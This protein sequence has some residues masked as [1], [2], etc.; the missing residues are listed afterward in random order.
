MRHQARFWLRSLN[1]QHLPITLP[2]NAN[3]W[4]VVL[5]GQPV[6]VRRKQRAYIIPLPAGEAGASDARDLT[7]L[8]ETDSPLPTAGDFWSRL[9]PRTIRQNAPQVALTTLSTTWNVHPPGGTDVVSSGGDF[10]P[11]KRLTRPTLAGWL[12]ETIAY[13]ST[14]GLAWKFGGLVV[15]A[16]V[17]GL[18]ALLGTGKGCAL[19]LVQLLVVTAVIGILIALLLPATQSA[20]EAARR[21]QCT[22]NLKQIGL[23]LHNYHER[24]GQFPPAAIGPAGVPRDRQFSWIVALLPFLE[25]QGL[26]ESLRLDLPWDDPQNAALLQVSLST[27]L[28]PSDPAPAATDEG[29]PKTSYVAITGAESTQGPGGTRG[30]LG[31]DKSLRLNEIVDGASGT[32]MVAEA[33]DGGPWFAGGFGTARRI[34]SWIETEAWSNHPGGGNVLLADG[35]VRFLASTIDLQTLRHLATAQ[36]AD[37]IADPDFAPSGARAAPADAPTGDALAPMP[38]T[39]EEQAESAAPPAARE[40]WA[41]AVPP[42]A[43]PVVKRGQ[44]ARLSLRVAIETQGKR[45]IR[46]R[47][48][49]GAGELVLE[50]QDQ[51]FARTL[52]WL[53]AAAALLAAWAWRRA[54]GTRRA[55]AVV[56]GLAAPVGLAGLVPLAWSPLADGVL[57]G[58]LAAACLWLVLS[59]AGA[60][61]SRLLART[62]AAV[63]LAI[64]ALAAADATAAEPAAAKEPPA[65][66]QQSRQP[67]LT[68]LIPYDPDG[69]DPMR[70]TRVYMPHDEFLR[71]WKQAHPGAPEQ[72]PAGVRPIVSHAEYAGRLENGLARFDGRLLIHHLGDG[73]VRV[74]L[75]LGDVALEK[76]E[77]DGQPATLAGR[78]T[79]DARQGPQDAANPAARPADEAPPADRGQPAIYLEK[80]G[81][82]VV[83]VR[84]SV[85]VHRLGATGQMTVPLRAAPSGRLLFQLPADDLDV[86]VSGAAGGWRRQPAP[87][88]GLGVAAGLTGEVVNIPLGANGELSIRWQPRHVEARTGQLASADQSVLVEVLDSGVHLQ[89]AVHYRIQQGSVSEVQLRIPPGM[90]IRS[91]HGADVADWS[92][93]DEPATAPD[94]AG[95]RLVVSLKTEVTTG[96]DV[97]ID[98]YYRDLRPAGAIG[99][100]ALEPVGVVRETGRLAIG[101]ASHF[102]VRVDEADRLNQV[103]H[104]ELDLPRKARD[105]CAVFSAYRYTARPWR[106]QLRVDRL[107]PRVEVADRTAVAVAERQASLR[108]LLTADVAGAP[109]AS[110]RLRLPAAM[111]VSQVRVPPGAEWFIQRGDKS[112]QLKVDWSEP[113]IGKLELAVAGS[114]ARDS[115]QAE[116]VVPGVVVEGVAAQRGQLAVY[117]DGD[118]EAVLASSGGARSIDPAALDGVLRV[119]DG[120]VHYA[121]QC[122]SPPQGLCLRLS[123]ASSRLTGG[124]TTV[125]SVR[126]GAVAYFSQVDFEIRQAGRSRFQIVSPAWL[127]DDIELRGEGIRQIRS[128]AANQTRTWEIELQQPVRDAYR[129]Q[130]VQTLPLPE[131]GTVPA[132]IIRP[133]GVE[134][135]RSHVVLENLTADE[136]AATT[137]GG[138]AAVSIAEVP[139]GLTDAVRRQAVAAYRVSGED[140]VLAWQRR[141]RA[142]ETG[143][144]ATISLADLTTVI[145]ADG[146]YRARAAYNIRNLTLQFLDLELPPHSQVWSV[147]VSGQPVRP[148]K[149]LRQ[150]RPVTLLPLQKISAGDFSSKVVVI[151]SGHLDG[152]LGRWTEVRPPAPRILSDIPVSRTLWTVLLPQE[153]QVRLVTHESNL[154]E[155]GAAYQQEERKLSFL[156]EL[157]QMAQVASIRGKSAAQ[158]KARYNL[159]QIGSALQN[160][161]RESVRV[162]ARNAPDVQQQAQQIEAE[163]RRLEELKPDAARVHGMEFYFEP[164]PQRE[165]GPRGADLERDFEKLSEPPAAG[166]KAAPP[167]AEKDLRDEAQGRPEQQRGKLREQAAEQLEKLQTKQQQRIQENEAAPQPSKAPEEADEADALGMMPGAER[168]S[169]GEPLAEGQAAPGA[170]AAG[171]GHLSLDLDL[172][173]VGIAHHFR[174]LHGQ[175]RLVLRVRHESLTRWLSAAVW[176]GLCLALAAAAIYGLRRPDAAAVARRG[177]PWLAALAGGAWLFL[178]PWGIFGLALLVTAVSVQIS[179]SRKQPP[180]EAASPP[181]SE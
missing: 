96:T 44:R 61:K 34:E 72:A 144:A 138:A 64:G 161:A 91:V 75:P 30:V 20:R 117:L 42:P 99:I 9:R 47:H 137:T 103:S 77:I 141:V 37:L 49:G 8:Y 12:A 98:G 25:Q 54:A 106:L 39:H 73:W 116:F 90:A 84:F 62:A 155:V 68:L 133:L 70:N 172:A 135:L 29:L 122:E 125:V 21:A 150:D 58:A 38:E 157:R 7:L 110:L 23:A 60:V 3:L 160:Y 181:I 108:S 140:A 101:C 66:N 102:R 176:A 26:Y 71:L 136:I 82:C 162:D 69:G 154:E 63:A 159:K 146:R 51:S 151:Y 165:G 170:P 147:Q 28:C 57:L 50:V 17:V 78:E 149:V 35:S 93:E 36:G 112:Q 79:A 14:S 120:P 33:T 89:S 128:Q 158:A 171:T 92:I 131:D 145:H 127:G 27:L 74:A 76:A 97:N 85:P 179:R 142:Q 115:S 18:F 45:P 32:A 81:L 143:A 80:A 53:L 174:K 173:L 119:G 94:R 10:N 153:Y 113:A 13:Q 56:A 180:V 59:I 31:F 166:E 4:T 139:E 164:P 52:Q 40:D 100:E 65:S 5:D 6:E 55:M 178:L 95:Q 11:V 121:F 46:F 48:E 1:L 67:D 175:P 19:N 114:V 16:I 177:W 109:I 156:D 152:P 111:R 2:E 126:E 87:P 132:A 43:Q 148:A 105:G 169:R 118:L 107:E 168:P 134:R 130:L 124:V 104:A 167:G 129:V 22:N 15:A 24:Y 41:A 83:D 88:A 123:P 163:I 86:E